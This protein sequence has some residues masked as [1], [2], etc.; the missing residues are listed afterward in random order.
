MKQIIGID[1]GVQALKN[2]MLWLCMF[3]VFMLSGTSWAQPAELDLEEQKQIVANEHYRGHLK[4]CERQEAKQRVGRNTH[5]FNRGYVGILIE[6][7]YQL[8]RRDFLHQRASP[9]ELRQMKEAYKNIYDNIMRL[10]SEIKS[11]EELI[12]KISQ[13]KIFTP[14]GPNFADPV[15]RRTGAEMLQ[16]N[17][18]RHLVDSRALFLPCE[19]SSSES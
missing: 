10:L 17:I 8:R 2:K 9:E 1:R 19:A 3:L 11:L 7:A 12:V 16:L 13:L 4:W 14:D 5:N 18:I 6:E 15:T